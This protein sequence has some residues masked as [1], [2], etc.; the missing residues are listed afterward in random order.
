MQSY[1]EKGDHEQSYHCEIPGSCRRT[2][3]LR[4][5]RRAGL[6]P[7]SRLEQV[8]YYEGVLT[9]DFS[10]NVASL[11]QGRVYEVICSKDSL[12]PL[13]PL[14]VVMQGRC[15]GSHWKCRFGASF[16]AS[17]IKEVLCSNNFS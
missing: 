15:N 8:D 4:V 5:G 14:F 13:S 7:R 1:S 17:A 16:T 3:A 6:P 9:E 10:G 12:S 11:E 2:G